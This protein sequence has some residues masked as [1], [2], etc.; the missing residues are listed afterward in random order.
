MESIN[1]DSLYSLSLEELASR[2]DSV[3]LQRNHER[4]GAL[5]KEHFP[6]DIP[7]ISQFLNTKSIMVPIIWTTI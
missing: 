1:I 3:I 5:P 6:K 4:Y 2:M 7:S